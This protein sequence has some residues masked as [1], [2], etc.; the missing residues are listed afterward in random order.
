MNLFFNLLLE[1]GIHLYTFAHLSFP[2]FICARSTVL[3]PVCSCV[4]LCWSPLPGHACLAFICACLCSFTFVPLFI[5]ARSVA[6]SHLFVFIHAGPL[7]LVMLIWP[8][9]MLVWACLSASN[10]QLAH[11]HIIIKKL[12]FVIYIIN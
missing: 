12:T 7:Y 8:L 2:L 9:F 11:T 5:C 6:G 4:H 3:V 10:T 1:L